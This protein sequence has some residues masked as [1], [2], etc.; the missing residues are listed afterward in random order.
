MSNALINIAFSFMCSLPAGSLAGEGPNTLDATL[1]L[2]AEYGDQ[3][4]KTDAFMSM[5]RAGRIWA[6]EE[7]QKIE[8]LGDVM[9]PEMSK[10]VRGENGKTF[11]VLSEHIN[12]G[13]KDNAQ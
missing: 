8:I 10:Q 5:Y 11:Y 1:A 13:Q 3:T 2:F 4:T 6:T 7:Q 12:C 9:K